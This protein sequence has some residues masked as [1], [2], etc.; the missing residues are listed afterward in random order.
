MAVTSGAVLAS[1]AYV[2]NELVARNV[3]ATLPEVTAITTDIEAMGTMSLPIWTRLEDMELT[4]TKI[5]V[6][7][8]LA[9]MLSGSSLS[10][11]L[12]WAQQNVDEFGNA[13]ESGCKAFVTGILKVVPGS[14]ITPGEPTENEVVYGAHRYQ[15]F[16]D[17]EEALC[18]DR[19]ANI[20]RING[21]DYAGNIE[22]YL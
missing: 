5:G 22:Q 1:T 19:F 20:C 3:A 12:R 8:G 18:I 17:G 14:E 7:L 21:V 10:V 6:D 9:E 13:Y 2:D 15:L 11:E 16:I 4:I